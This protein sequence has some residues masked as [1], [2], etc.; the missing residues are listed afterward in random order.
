MWE[1]WEINTKFWVE[2]LVLERIMLK[3]FLKKYDLRRLAGF[4]WI[5]TGLRGGL[6]EHDCSP[7]FKKQ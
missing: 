4:T 7:L 6:F 2:N 1:S 3:L 5:I